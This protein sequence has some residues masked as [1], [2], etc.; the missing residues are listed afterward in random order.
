[1][2]H[3]QRIL[4]L[5]SEEFRRS[6]AKVW[7]DAYLAKAITEAKGNDMTHDEIE[8][9]RAELLTAKNQTLYGPGE[10]IKGALGE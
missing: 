7:G 9:L 6:I 1:M 2:L 8:R 4:L 10:T 3:F 5:K